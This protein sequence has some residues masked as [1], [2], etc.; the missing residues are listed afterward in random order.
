[1]MYTPQ[2]GHKAE[3][4]LSPPRSTDSLNTRLVQIARYYS[5]KT[6]L[7]QRLNTKGFKFGDAVIVNEKKGAEQ[8]KG[9]VIGH[10][11]AFCTI[12]FEPV[13]TPSERLCVATVP[14]GDMVLKAHMVPTV[15][16]MGS[17]SIILTNNRR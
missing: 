10:T 6:C 16:E 8:S 13:N 5:K 11:P 9:Y 17:N 4:V 3:K 12:V 14:N 7:P 2:P 1:M 15:L